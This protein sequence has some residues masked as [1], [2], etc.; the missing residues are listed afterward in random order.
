MKL[1]DK[2]KPGVL[3][4]INTAGKRWPY[5]HEAIITF[6]KKKED[7]RDLTIEEIRNTC[8]Y[9]PERYQPKDIFDLQYGDWLIA[10]K[11]K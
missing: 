4:S 8:T 3:I 6:L 10:K 2:I 7:Y 5:S 11:Y 1:I 9:L